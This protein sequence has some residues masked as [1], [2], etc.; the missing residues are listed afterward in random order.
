MLQ[1][2]EK[3]PIPLFHKLNFF[4]RRKMVLL[5]QMD[6]TCGSV[7]KL[8]LQTMHYFVTRKL[9]SLNIPNTSKKGISN[10]VNINSC[11]FQQHLEST[12]RTKITWVGHIR[13][14]RYPNFECTKPP[15]NT[16]NIGAWFQL[17]M[18]KH[19]GFVPEFNLKPCFIERA[20]LRDHNLLKSCFQLIMNRA[21]SKNNLSA[22]ILK[23]T[24]SPN[25]FI[26]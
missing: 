14:N 13:V 6:P 4:L 26:N 15:K 5:K 12:S 10:H 2:S 8:S 3:C 21:I 19:K 1:K 24:P 25:P 23:I 18:L 20:N 16:I 7:E 22:V 9:Q 11:R 17:H